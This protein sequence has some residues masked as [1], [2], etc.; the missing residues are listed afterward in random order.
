MLR[1]EIPSC[2]AFV[3]TGRVVPWIGEHLQTEQLPKQSYF[4]CD[5]Q[6]Q[7]QHAVSMLGRGLRYGVN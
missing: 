7:G 4:K 2:A 3:L 1:L 5:M 6:A